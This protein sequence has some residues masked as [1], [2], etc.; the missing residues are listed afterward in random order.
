[1]EEQ[2]TRRARILLVDDSPDI[3]DLYQRLINKQTDLECVGARTS[4]QELE[5][6]VQESRA[7]LAVIDLV[8]TGRNAVAAIEA[9]TASCPDCL[10]VVFSGHDDSA[11]RDRVTRAGAWSLVSKN[12]HPMKL[13]EE[14]RRA[15]GPMIET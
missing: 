10:I 1:V 13:L 7:D 8:G 2:M 4:T 3:L 5:A 9:T 14:I 6:A 12:D 11:T 15:L